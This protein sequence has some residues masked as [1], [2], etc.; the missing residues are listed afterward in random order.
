MTAGSCVTFSG[1]MILCICMLG[2]NFPANLPKKTVKK[3]GSNP[4][5]KAMKGLSRTQPRI[6]F[7]RSAYCGSDARVMTS[8]PP[9]L[10][11]ITKTGTDEGSRVRM[12]DTMSDI[13]REVGPVRPLSLGFV[14]ECPQPRWSKAW[15]SIPREANVGNSS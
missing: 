9:I 4:L 7:I 5:G 11:P 6:S 13:T 3:P 12:K 10:W 8:P 15:V 2:N 14:T 1:G